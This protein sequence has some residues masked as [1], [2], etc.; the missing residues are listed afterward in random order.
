[1]RLKALSERTPFSFY[2]S[3][4]I[5][6]NDH[7]NIY[8]HVL[9]IT[10]CTKNIH[11]LITFVN[12]WL[13]RGIAQLHFI[14]SLIFL[15]LLS[16]ISFIILLIYKSQLQ[17]WN[18]HLFWRVSKCVK[19]MWFINKKNDILLIYSS[20]TELLCHTDKCKKTHLSVFV[21]SV[22]KHHYFYFLAF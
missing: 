17:L 20:L 5:L 9:G 3:S 4:N 10:I 15:L 12:Y 21:F 16:I 14:G 2:L 18:T 6:C 8:T 1:M 7:K 19:K 22:S 11:I 13:S